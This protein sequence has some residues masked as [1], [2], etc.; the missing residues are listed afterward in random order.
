MLLVKVLFIVCY[1][2]VEAKSS[3]SGNAPVWLFFF[4]TVSVGV[5]ESVRELENSVYL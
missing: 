1:Y 2:T 3:H 4:F 5:E